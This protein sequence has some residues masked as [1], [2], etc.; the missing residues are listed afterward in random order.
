LGVFLPIIDR[1]T[2]EITTRFNERNSE[3]YAEISYLNP[4]NFH[5]LTDTDSFSMRCLASLAD[6]D[7]L[8]LKQELVHFA[9]CHKHLGKKRKTVT[10]KRMKHLIQMKACVFVKETALIAWALF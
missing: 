3:L 4:S 9:K 8:V 1:L 6:V 7:E 5:N 2:D 10:A